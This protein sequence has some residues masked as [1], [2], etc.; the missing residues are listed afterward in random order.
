LV[1]VRAKSGVLHF[2]R[3]GRRAIQHHCR[4]PR[5]RT[6]VRVRVRVRI[7]IRVRVRVRASIGVN[8]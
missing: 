4:P 6:C 3:R 7:R 2:E 5:V 1:L 8:D